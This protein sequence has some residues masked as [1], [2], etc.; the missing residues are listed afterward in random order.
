MIITYSRYEV[1]NTITP[2]TD[3]KFEFRNVCLCLCMHKIGMLNFKLESF[4][5]DLKHVKAFR[6]SK[7]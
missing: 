3:E 5:S 4:N 7:C 6:V 1:S 2:F